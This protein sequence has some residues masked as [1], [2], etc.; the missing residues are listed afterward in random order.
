MSALPPL[1]E[2]DDAEM[3]R[4]E[5][6]P[7]HRRGAGP[8]PAMHEDHRLPVRAPGLLPVHAVD[9]V[10]FQHAGGIGLNGVEQLGAGHVGSIAAGTQGGGKHG[11]TPGY[12][13][14]GACPENAQHSTAMC[15][16]PNIP[17]ALPMLARIAVAVGVLA[18]GPAAAAG[19][20][21]DAPGHLNPAGPA[22]SPR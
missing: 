11:R 12:A 18:A 8:R 15:P 1:V 20:Q 22:P 7:V 21:V 6:P 13:L 2:H 16:T 3:V 5:E 4:V 14:L 10:A 19:K 9:A 17:A